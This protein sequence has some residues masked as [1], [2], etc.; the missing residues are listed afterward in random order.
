MYYG[1]MVWMDIV[2]MHNMHAINYIF[3]GFSSLSRVDTRGARRVYSV[4]LRVIYDIIGIKLLS[5]NNSRFSRFP[6]KKSHSK[7]SRF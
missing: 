3:I 2:H 5:Y 4:K 1:Y 7:V 6:K